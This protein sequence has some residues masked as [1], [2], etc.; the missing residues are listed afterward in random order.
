MN[1]S[2]KLMSNNFEK[3]DFIRV[4]KLISQSNPIL[5]QNKYVREF[6][7]S[8]SKWLGVKYSVFVNSGS[9]AN[10]LTLAVLSQLKKNKNKNEIIV[11]AFTWISD[12]VSIIKNGF[13]P[14]F[15]DIDKRNL[16]MDI[17][18]V[19]KKIN[20]KTLAIFITHAQGFN[21]FN[22]E[23]L[24]IA[25]KKKII[26]L[27][28]VCES[29]GATF[30]GKKLGSF[31]LISNFSF[32]YAHHLSTIEGGMVCTNDKNIYEVARSFRSHGMAREMDN[33]VLENKYIKKYKLLSPKFIFLY[34]GFNFRS[35]EISALIG[36]N[37]LKRLDKQNKKRAINL[38]IFLDN[39]DKS[40]YWTN[41]DLEGN[42]NYAFPLVLKKASLKNRNRLEIIL[43]K[44]KIEFRRGNVG[45]G[46]QLRQPYL[47]SY[48]K[49]IN[50]KEFKVVDHI[51]F[52]GYYIGN[53]PS[54]KKEKIL[55]ICKI[56]NELFDE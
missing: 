24:N 30:K 51:H 3:N 33:K 39:L 34:Q 46:N 14:I 32:Y 8:W 9:S 41:F 29:H 47:K 16:C 6:E 25:K 19:K 35:N 11:P 13:K 23:I 18:L 38:K 17:E 50:L 55:K 15:V 49:K 1:F 26:I 21:G 31:G 4:K 43:K 42:S 52:F 5:T 12:L 36:I 48:L 54:L 28:D 7:Q 27:E 20:K 22:N 40:I 44:K 45:G 53:Y 2:H 10:F 56:L 37:Q